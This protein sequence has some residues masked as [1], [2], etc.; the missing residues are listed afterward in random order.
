LK[1]IQ[2]ADG[3]FTI[4]AGA[5]HKFG[6]YGPGEC[7]AVHPSGLRCKHHKNHVGCHSTYDDNTPISE[8]FKHRWHA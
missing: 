1:T 2:H 6:P 4:D 3:S 8:K 5:G 7:E